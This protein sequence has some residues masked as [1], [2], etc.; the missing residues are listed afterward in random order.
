MKKLFTFFLITLLYACSSSDDN[1]TPNND[2]LPEGFEVPA[3][4]IEVW[5][6][7]GKTVTYDG[8]YV[9]NNQSCEDD[10]IFDIKATGGLIIR[11]PNSNCATSNNPTD[12][13]F[14]E[15][16]VV[17]QTQNEIT[18]TFDGKI[19]TNEILLLDETFLIMKE[20]SNNQGEPLD[21]FYYHYRNV[22]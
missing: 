16:F 10:W 14:N 9:I 19:Q 13:V 4:L 21:E 6:R 22:N 8:N 2:A 18:F 17:N 15:E 11:F 7:E 3:L 12:T 20:I 5:N 1:P